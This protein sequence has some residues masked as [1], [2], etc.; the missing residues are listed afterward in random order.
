MYELYIANKNYSSWSL[1]PWLLMKELNIPF[2][3]RLERF[4]DDTTAFR[5]FSPSG[6]VPCL[7][8]GATVVYDSLAIVE[9]LAE[10]HP[11]V[12][13]QDDAARAWARCAC[14]EMH[15]G[16]FTLRGNCGMN[17]GLR[18][19][20]H[21]ISDALRADLDRVEE[22]W[23]EGIER[24]GGPFLAG[25]RFCAVDAFFGPVAFRLQTYQ[26]PVG[27]V[28]NRYAQRLLELPAMKQWYADALQ[29]PWRDAEHEEDVLLAGK[30]IEDLRR[31]L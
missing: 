20:L 2:T 19:R 23:T 4:T 9:Y 28:A 24:F 8:D 15:S 22:L 26:P 16:F 18:V 21:E 11:G 27:H 12:W 6:R 10:R 25:D 30:V 1:R 3:E 17:C 14:A 31:P 29:E 13:P 5:R 7:H